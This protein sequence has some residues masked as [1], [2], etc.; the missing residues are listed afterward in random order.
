MPLL[1]GTL[2]DQLENDQDGNQANHHGGHIHRIHSYLPIIWPPRGGTV[3]SS[4][5]DGKMRA[6]EAAPSHCGEQLG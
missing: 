5:A 6:A 2:V 4:F 1:D 3:N